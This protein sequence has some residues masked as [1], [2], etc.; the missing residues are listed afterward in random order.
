ML[1][2]PEPQRSILEDIII[3][4][5]HRLPGKLV[6]VAGRADGK[7]ESSGR[8]RDRD[9]Y[10]DRDNSKENGNRHVSINSSGILIIPWA[11]SRRLKNLAEGASFIICRSGYSTVMDLVSAGRTALLVPT[12]GQPEQEY[13][14]VYLADRHGFSTVSQKE[15]A[16]GF[17]PVAE[18]AGTAGKTKWLAESNRL[19]SQALDDIVSR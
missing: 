13:L 2:G 10:S 4:Q 18:G 14:A 15:L 17:I 19:L 8:S 3:S 7:E 9:G 12:P 5:R 6:V 11:D 1:S 16:A